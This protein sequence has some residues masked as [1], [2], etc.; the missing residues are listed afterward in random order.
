[1]VQNTVLGDE[2]ISKTIIGERT[3]GWSTSFPSTWHEDGFFLRTDTN[4]F[5]QNTGTEST[6][7]WTQIFQQVDL[8]LILALGD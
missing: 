2:A 1:M 3:F 8:G 7:V 6:P 5:Y 4:I